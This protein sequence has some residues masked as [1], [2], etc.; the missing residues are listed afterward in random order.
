[1]NSS[2][3]QG[4]TLGYGQQGQ[5]AQKATG[6][7]DQVTANN[8]QFNG[9]VQ[10]TPYY[11]SLLQSGTSSTNAAYDNAARNL[12]QSMQGAGVSGASGAAAGNTAAM[13]AQR[14]GA[15][16]QVGTNAVQGATQMQQGANA[17][18]LQTA[19]MFSGAGLGYYSGANQAELQRL[20]IGR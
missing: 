19:G 2:P 7:A 3:S 4:E 8:S 1:M 20:Q 11:K 16:G 10:Q 17:Q 9:P 13:G 5:D 14:A 15:L 6:L 12:K 18:Q